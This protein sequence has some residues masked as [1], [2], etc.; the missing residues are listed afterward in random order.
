VIARIR[1]EL[2]VRDLERVEVMTAGG[3]CYEVQIPNS[4][5]E[6]LPKLGEQVTLRTY[7]IVREDAHLLFGFLEDVERV[8]FMRLLSA[9]GVG[10]RL[11]LST[12]GALGAASVVRAIREK[13]SVALTSVSG[14]GK[15]TAER[16]VLELAGKMDDIALAPAGVGVRAPGV[17]EAMRALGAL[18]VVMADAERAVRGVI[19]DAG[20]LPAPE[21]IKQALARLK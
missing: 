2:V 3:V 8:V 10:P 20:H 17:E 6:R 21:L 14:V 15:K 19:Q 11:A 4:V 1:G 7:Q 9:N 18:G 13:N 16:I 5:F 12:V